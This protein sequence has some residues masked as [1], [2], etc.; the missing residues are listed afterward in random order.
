VVTAKACDTIR[1][2]VAFAAD[3]SS[4]RSAAA[5]T[6]GAT[7]TAATRMIGPTV[8]SGVLSLT[9]T[10]CAGMT[11]TRC[12]GMTAAT[13]CSAGCGAWAAAV[14]AIPR[15]LAFVPTKV[16]A[17][18][19][20]VVIYAAIGVI[21]TVAARPLVA[22]VRYGRA[23]GCA[24]RCLGRLV[25]GFVDVFI[26]VPAAVTARGL[27]LALAAKIGRLPRSIDAVTSRA[28]TKSCE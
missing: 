10:R 15:H 27:Y 2:Q 25:C 20:I 14:L 28:A 3:G 6:A 12:A 21:E 23:A 1:S 24:L 7:G 18:A 5:S 22:V 4:L 19:A 8:L 26:V 9:A 13:R 16:S 11:A 17:A